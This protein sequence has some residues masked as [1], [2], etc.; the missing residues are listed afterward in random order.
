MIR[1]L[2]YQIICEGVETDQQIEILKQIGCDEIQ[3]YWYSKPLKEEDYDKLLQTENISKGGAI[4]PNRQKILRDTL[5]NEKTKAR[6]NN[7]SGREGQEL[8]GI[9]LLGNQKTKYPDDYAPE[10]LETFENK[11]PDND[12]FVKFNA[13]EFTSLCPITGQP[14]F[15]TI[16][17]SYVP[18]ERMVE[19][20]SLKLY[21]YSFRNHGDFHEDCMNIIMKDLIKLMDPKYIEVWGKIYTERRY[22]YRSIL[23]LW[24]TRNKMGGS[25]MEQI[26]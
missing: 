23:Q 4:P 20:K 14:D 24:K 6:N 8:E 16:Y 12:Y 9:T 19:S 21:L 5:D 11:H 7:M 13:P 26:I 25:C 1:N 3:G 17:I 18:G 2:G 22:F 10:V 15:A